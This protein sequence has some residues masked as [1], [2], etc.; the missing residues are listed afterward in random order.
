MTIAVTTTIKARA[1]KAG[2]TSSAVTAATYAV[3]AAGAVDTPA[4]TPGGGWFTAQ[5]IV[6]ITAQTPG[7]VI[8]YT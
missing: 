6:T 1:Y 8:H 2:Y 3:D 4:L 7:A 5:Q